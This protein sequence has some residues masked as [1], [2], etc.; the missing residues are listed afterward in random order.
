MAAPVLQ[1]GSGTISVGITASPTD[2]FECQIT[3]FRVTASANIGQVSGT[4]CTG[5][6]SYAQKSNFSVDM[7]FLSDFGATASLSDLLW[8][9]D[10]EI[11]HFKFTPSDVTIPEATGT[12]Y[13]VAPTFGGEGDSLWTSTGSMPCPEKPTLTA[14]EPPAAAKAAK[15]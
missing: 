14:Q 2:Q 3:D 1:F 15:S 13:A 5:P 12:F 7:A 8:D 9:N 4:Y 11:L 6:S 10:G